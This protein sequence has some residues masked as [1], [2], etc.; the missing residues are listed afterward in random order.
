MR[1]E[2]VHFRIPF[3]YEFYGVFL[4]L[5]IAYD[6]DVADSIPDDDLREQKISDLDKEWIL[7]L[8][9]QIKEHKNLSYKKV[10]EFTALIKHMRDVECELDEKNKN[11]EDTTELKEILNDL[12]KYHSELV[13]T[14]RWTHE[15]KGRYAT[16]WE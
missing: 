15:T 1:Y 3:F 13:Y 9:E 14:R 10:A 11:C 5:M 4:A 6:L 7:Q 2:N 12:S 16:E 8:A